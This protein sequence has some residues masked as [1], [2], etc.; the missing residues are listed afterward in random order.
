MNSN[1]RFKV[2]TIKGLKDRLPASALEWFHRYGVHIDPNFEGGVPAKDELIKAWAT[3]K[4]KTD[5]KDVYVLWCREY[6]EDALVPDD[7]FP[8]VVKK[9]VKEEDDDEA[10]W[11]RK[12]S[13]NSVPPSSPS[14][15]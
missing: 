6:V 11:S 13:P 5:A 10:D 7:L 1:Q 4:V 3:V 8:G 12:M 15:P 14:P 2:S 9:E